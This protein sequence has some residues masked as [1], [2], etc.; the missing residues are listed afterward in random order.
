MA[1]AVE[2][3]LNK[4]LS[5]PLWYAASTGM[6]TLPHPALYVGPALSFGVSRRVI[7]IFAGL[8]IGDVEDLSYFWDL[9]SDL[10]FYALP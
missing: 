4:L 8:M 10:S 6:P 7:R 9:L 3:F 1:I 2:S 5:L